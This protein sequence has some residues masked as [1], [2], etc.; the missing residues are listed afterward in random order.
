M[1]ENTL[2]IV[3]LAAGKG[4]RM[5]SQQPKVLHK[6]AGRAMIEHV[7]ATATA[8]SPK[9]MLAVLAPGM[10]RVAEAV[11]PM[12]TV[13]QEPQLGTG[14][15]VRMARE[16]LT[17]FTGDVLV[18]YA[19]NPLIRPRTL[20]RMIAA[21]REAK[22][23]APAAVVLGFQPE[24]AGEYGR[25]IVD[26][27]GELEAIVEFRD[28]NPEQRRLGLCNSGVMLIDGA[29]L[30]ALLDEIGN[31]NAK[32]EYYLTDIV[33]AARARGL[34]CAVV[35][36]AADEVL[37]VN[38]RAE[39]AAA[40]AVCQSRLR[41]RFMADGVTLIDP[42][43][44]FFSFDT[45]LG[46]DVVIEP[47]V[48]FGPGVEVGDNVTLRAFS[49]I[50]GAY[51][52]DRATIGPFARLRPGADIGE[53]A[54]VGNFVEIKNACIETGAKVNHLTYIGDAH[55]GA[56]A[57]IGAGTITCNYDGFTKAL[58]EIGA[59]AFIGSN[60]A[61]VAPVNVGRGAI[62]GAG[63]V[64][65]ADVPADALA[66]TRAPQTVKEGWAA[67]FRQRQRPKS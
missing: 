26:A 5:K 24:D 19:D 10:D 56:R 58:T 63:S 14:H 50:E 38:S 21:R 51:I 48:F 31:D 15:A 44:V 33:A 6:V 67:K 29:V 22:G 62:V 13:V 40:E 27:A 30:F 23:T 59:D 9:R 7:V 3:I 20:E 1:S 43:S 42:G 57:N 36:A 18:L 16:A 11:A 28:A 46:R 2:A 35:E 47:H 64:I 55:I 34:H 49:H 12:P 53:A 37:G 17:D 32:G 66:L 54:R 25:L 52:G 45:Q 8:L 60:T 41:A 65:S 39:L 61:L 4:T